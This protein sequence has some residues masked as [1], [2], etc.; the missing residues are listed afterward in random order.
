MAKIKNVSPWANLKITSRGN[1]KTVMQ[2]MD[3][4]FNPRAPRKITSRGMGKTKNSTPFCVFQQYLS[5][6]QQDKVFF[7]LWDQF[8]WHFQFLKLLNWHLENSQLGKFL[9][10]LENPKFLKLSLHFQKLHT[11]LQ[12]KFYITKKHSQCGNYRN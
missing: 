3:K 4:K 8:Q 10:L 5:S 12:K 2:E 7:S 9:C 1:K 6:K 11:V